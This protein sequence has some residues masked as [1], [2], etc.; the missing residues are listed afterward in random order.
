MSFSANVKNIGTKSQTPKGRPTGVLMALVNPSITIAQAKVFANWQTL[1]QAGDDS[2]RLYYFS[3]DQVTP[4]NDAAKNENLDG[5]KVV[6]I[7][8]DAGADM[9]KLH[10]PS[11]NVMRNAYTWNGATVYIARVYSEGFIRAKSADE[12]N[13][14]FEKAQ[15]FVS[16][17]KST[18][19]ATE[20]LVLS[21]QTDPQDI[22]NTLRYQWTISQEEC[23]FQ[24]VDFYS[25]IDA[26]I[27]VNSDISTSS[28]I[29]FTVKSKEGLPI[30]GLLSA[31]ISIYDESTPETPETITA[32]T[33]VTIAG[34]KYYK[35][36]FGTPLSAATYVVS[37][38]SPET[39]SV[40]GYEISETDTFIVGS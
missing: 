17:E 7:G 21:V 13:F 25:L 11:D 35:V 19:D 12:I 3:A 27:E 22:A 16:R 40:K 34:V 10:S 20:K 32:L 23:D 39:L 26:A 31:D 38:V 1:L 33:S 14:D 18:N 37:A 24:M 5:G 9:F 6:Q 29:F 8:M 4:N 30:L 28:D 15:V 36:H 2:L